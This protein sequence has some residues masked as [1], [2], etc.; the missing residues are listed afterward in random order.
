MA[1]LHRHNMPST[2]F[3]VPATKNKTTCPSSFCPFPEI[4]MGNSHFLSLQRLLTESFR[5]FLSYMLTA[6]LDSVFLDV[7]RRLIATPIKRQEHVPANHCDVTSYINTN[8]GRLYLLLFPNMVDR[9][10]R[11]LA[12]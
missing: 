10:E 1:S 8:L 2:I 6:V 4:Q 3:N 11:H 7:N 5:P 9:D 12:L